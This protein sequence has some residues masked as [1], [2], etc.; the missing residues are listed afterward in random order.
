MAP[1]LSDLESSYSWVRSTSSTLPMPSQRGHMPPVRLKLARLVSPFTVIVP[2]ARTEAVLKENALGPPMCG[3]PSR[4]NRMRSMALASVAVP[5]VERALAPIRSWSTMIG[6]RQAVEH[7]DVGPRHR[8]HEA[9]DEGA[10][11]LVDQPLGLGGD[12]A[13]H[14]RALARAGHAGEHRQPA[15]R[16]LDADVLEVVLPCALHPDQVVAVG[17]VG[18]LA[19]GCLLDADQVARRVADGAVANAVRLVGRLLDDLDVAGLE[20]LEGAV[21]V[22]GGQVDHGVGALGHHL[23][24]GAALVVGDAGVDGRRVEDDG[25]LRLVGR[26]DGDPA[27]PLVADVEADLEAEGVAVEG[28]RGIR[29]GVREHARVNGDVH[30]AHDKDGSGAGASRF[31]TGRVT[32][33]ATQGGIPA[34]ARVASRR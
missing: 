28:Q 27:H 1:S 25:R 8:R 34:V 13:E 11:G 20:P 15:L 19:H 33:F 2:A 18:G 10:V 21:D 7:V 23:G 17:D 14:Q 32:C 26:A 24:D 4:L 16:D 9:L 12:G 29:V 3:L 30:G 22:L 5:T 31:L 6:G